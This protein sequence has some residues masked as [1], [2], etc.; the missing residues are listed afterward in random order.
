MPNLATHRRHFAAARVVGS[1]S[2]A[3]KLETGCHAEYLA[4]SYPTVAAIMGRA[5]FMDL[6]ALFA[7]EAELGDAQFPDW[8]DQ[9]RTGQ[10]LPYLSGV[11]AIDRLRCEAEG[12]MPGSAVAP[13][14]A[15]ALTTV[16]WMRSRARLD[17]ATR[18]GWFSVP[19]PSIWLA[20]FDAALVDSAPEWRAE[21]ILITRSAGMLRARRIGPA[22]HR[23]LAGLRIGEAVDIATSA[24][25]VLYPGANIELA[26]KDIID[27]GAAASVQIVTRGG[28]E[29]RD[30]PKSGE[31]A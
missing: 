8:I 13:T 6:A 15:A 5:P 7:A 18:F 27:S 2:V 17:P 9:Q 10:I 22:E 29:V 25:R 12:A 20:H 3:A 19:A 14:V 24:A 1:A 28:D 11:A 4:R 16:E 31:A 26:I 23:I 21:G 30:A